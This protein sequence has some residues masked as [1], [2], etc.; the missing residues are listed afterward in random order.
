MEACHSAPSAAHSASVIDTQPVSRQQAPR[1]SAAPQASGS[2]ASSPRN[3]PA[4]VAHSS[5]VVT[6]Q[7]FSAQQ[8]PS[9]WPPQSAASSS[10]EPFSWKTPPPATQL[11]RAARVQLPL[12]QQAPRT[13][14][15]HSSSRSEQ[16]PSALKTPPRSA[17]AASLPK[18]QEP[19]AQ[20]E[21]LSAVPQATSAQ[22][23]PSLKVPPQVVAVAR[24]HCSPSQQAP[25]G[26]LS[27]QSSRTSQRS[28][29]QLPP[30]KSQA[31]RVASSQRPL[32][33]QQP[34]IIPRPVQSKAGHST[35]STK[36]PSQL[37]TSSPVQ[38]SSTQHAPAGVPQRPALQ[39]APVGVPPPS[40]QPSSVI[41]EQE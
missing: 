32:G 7:R 1:S 40:V 24:R 9:A 10:H 39:L 3:S 33:R 4:R 5:L 14:P 38:T 30:L 19:P 11:W 21:P 2:H 36:L 28:A 20:Q 13:A 12:A 37:S 23:M 27:S 26:R 31:A 17:H 15:G 8:L 22:I 16:S 29:P 18:V 35:P 25:S 41:M 34:P 6:A